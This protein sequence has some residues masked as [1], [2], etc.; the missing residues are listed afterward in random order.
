MKCVISNNKG[1]FAK[2]WFDVINNFSFLKIKK[3]VIPFTVKE[4][5]K[6]IDEID[7]PDVITEHIEYKHVYVI[8]FEQWAAVAQLGDMICADLIIRRNIFPN[9]SQVREYLWKLGIYKEIEILD[10]YIMR[11]R[12]G[13][14]KI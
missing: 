8:E 9:N 7:D 2:E 4:R 10:C 14:M 13:E 11:N 6:R 5:R 12:Q 3:Y 1:D